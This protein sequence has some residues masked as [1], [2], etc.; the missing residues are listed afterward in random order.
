MRIN[1]VNGVV[2]LFKGSLRDAEKLTKRWVVIQEGD[3][4]QQ[5]FSAIGTKVKIIQ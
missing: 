4:L 2:P 5:L 3:K 1:K